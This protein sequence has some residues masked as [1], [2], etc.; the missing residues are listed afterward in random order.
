MTGR[1]APKRDSRIAP[2]LVQNPSKTSDITV[3]ALGAAGDSRDDLIVGRCCRLEDGD[4]A[5]LPQHRI[6]S[7]IA[8]TSPRLCE[9]YT[10]AWS[11]ARSRLTALSTWAVEATPSAA[12]GSSSNRIHDSVPTA[13]AIAIAWRWPPESTPTFAR[14][15]FR[16]RTS[17]RSIASRALSSMSRV[18]RGRSM[19]GRNLV[20]P[21]TTGS[22]P[23]NRL[24]V[25]SR[26]SHNACSWQQST[27][28]RAAWPRAARGRRT[29]WSS[30]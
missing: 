12:V 20:Q 10:I 4:V 15:D 5:A 17:N 28:C 9:M 8:K 13:R 21:A 29:S 7:Q 23:R 3:L 25:T 22:W 1:N 14:T 27:G 24:A 19:S 2:N 11:S 6:R 30:I 16:V 18:S 26:F